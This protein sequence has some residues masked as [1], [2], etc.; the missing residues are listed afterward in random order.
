MQDN[1]KGSLDFVGSGLFCGCPAVHYVLKGTSS[2]ASDAS[3]DRIAPPWSAL[4]ETVATLN[5]W[6]LVSSG[7]LDHLNSVNEMCIVLRGLISGNSARV[8][9]ACGN[10]AG[11]GIRTHAVP[12]WKPS[13]FPLGDARLKRWS[14]EWDLNPRSRDYRSRALPAELS[15]DSETGAGCRSRTRVACL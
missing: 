8:P 7:T 6:S 13:A 11:G 14:R 1:V 2:I 4:F 5:D 15:L 9:F 3:N 12:G 10:G